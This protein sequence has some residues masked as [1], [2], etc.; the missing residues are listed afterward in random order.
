MYDLKIFALLV[1]LVY[2]PAIAADYSFWVGAINVQQTRSL[3]YDSNI[4]AITLN[5]TGV[6]PYAYSR[7]LG[8]QGGQSSAIYYY[9]VDMLGFSFTADPASSTVE[10]A[11]SIVNNGDGDKANALVSALINVAAPF[12][13]AAI[14]IPGV[15][16]IL[17]N[18]ESLLGTFSSLC[19]GVVVADILR[20]T[21]T[22]LQALAAN[23]Y[24]TTISYPGRPS[25]AGCG[26][27]SNYVLA[28]YLKQISPA[29]SSLSSSTAP[30]SSAL[31]CSDSPLTVTRS[32]GA[33]ALTLPVA[34]C[35][36]ASA[37]STTSNSTLVASASTSVAAH[38]TMSQAANATSTPTGTIATSSASP[39]KS[40][41]SASRAH[42]WSSHEGWYYSTVIL[43]GTFLLG[44]MK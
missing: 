28:V 8:D 1:L 38:S 36:S 7:T 32:S 26:S 31:T 23:E 39:T 27:N 4:A 6:S 13:S 16:E 33:S 40:S 43:L 22:Q 29:S 34:Q 24:Q 14:G 37:S 21:P 41:S 18:V 20:F 42:R 19:D 15:T 11:Y 17:S 44:L 5:G 2:Q 10:L 12:V 9:T 35:G 25:P 3:H 30:T